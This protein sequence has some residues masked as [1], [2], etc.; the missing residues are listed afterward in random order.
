MVS[1]RKLLLDVK[2]VKAK[3]DLEREKNRFNFIGTLHKEHD[4]VNLHSRFI[5]YLL[6]PHSNHGFKEKFAEIFIR[7]A[8]KLDE[9]NFDLSNNE[10]FPNEFNKSEY[11][12]IDILGSAEKHKLFDL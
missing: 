10:V 8:I 5:S 11:K 1:L 9:E 4:E 7:E 12:N 3:Y 2:D 6:A